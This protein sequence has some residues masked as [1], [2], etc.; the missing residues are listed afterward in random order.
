VQLTQW[1]IGALKLTALLEIRGFVTRA[2]FKT[3]GIDHRRW[4]NDPNWLVPTD[5]PGQFA[6]GPELR[7]DQQHPMVYA[8]IRAEI[9]KQQKGSDMFS[10]E[11]A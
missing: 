10:A 11:V 8:E 9:E 5:R 3:V 6:R 7:F 2:D 4:V 1:K